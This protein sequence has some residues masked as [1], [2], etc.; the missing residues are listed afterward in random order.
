MAATQTLRFSFLQERASNFFSDCTSMSLAPQG[1]LIVFAEIKS[2]TL[3]GVNELK[4]SATNSFF[5]TDP[6][7]IESDTLSV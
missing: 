1:S 3:L 7:Y 5:H 4:I 6:R 2:L